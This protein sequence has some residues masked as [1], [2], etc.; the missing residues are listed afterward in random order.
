MKQRATQSRA[1][2]ALSILLLFFL[3]AGTSQ[4]QHLSSPNGRLQL[5]VALTQRGQPTYTL[6]LEDRVVIQ[7]SQLG[8]ELSG[9]R[10]LVDGFSVFSADTTSTD[11]TWSPVWGQ[12]R[13]IRN[14]YRELAVTLVQSGDG[15]R[16]MILRFRLFDDGLGFRYEFPRRTTSGILVSPARSQRST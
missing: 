5:D 2:M 4:A 3:L 16:S 7:E 9:T 13:S 1:T 10:S 15:D 8:I 14:N 11:E 12:E 6:S